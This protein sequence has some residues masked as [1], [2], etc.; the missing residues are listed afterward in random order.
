M[1]VNLDYEFYLKGRTLDY[2]YEVDFEEQDKVLI[3]I[4]A[5]DYKID[6][7]T[8]KR[9]YNDF[10]LFDQLYDE[11]AEEMNE[12]LLEKFRDKAY[13]EAIERLWVEWY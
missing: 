11:Y 13:Q 7:K 1:G 6:Y 5:R 10:D 12:I 3:G 2:T 9:L 8:A 4:L